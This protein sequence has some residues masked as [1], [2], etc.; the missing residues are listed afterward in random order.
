MKKIAKV[1]T[2]KLEEET[3]ENPSLKMMAQLVLN[4]IVLL[5]G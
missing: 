4:S 5:V 2:K 3:Y 1:P